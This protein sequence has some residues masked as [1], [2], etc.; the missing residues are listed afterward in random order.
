[1]KRETMFNLLLGFVMVLALVSGS[2]VV[3][4]A[5]AQEPAPQ[6]G[7]APQADVS[8]AFTYQGRLTDDSTGNP[9]AGPCDFQFS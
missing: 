3:R 1:M 9:I 5:R 7:L 6:G 4:Q 2:T 8:T